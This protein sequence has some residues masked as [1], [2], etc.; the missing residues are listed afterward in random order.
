MLLPPGSEGH[1]LGTD[2]F[3]RDLL[4]RVVAA[5]GLSMLMAVGITAFVIVL[6]LVLGS[7]AGF[8]GGKTETG[9]IGLIDLT[10]GFPLLLV[11]VIFAGMVGKGLYALA[12]AAAVVLWAGFARIIRAQVKDPA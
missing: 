2:N 8:L 5:I 7:I 3:G 12:G 11:A 9:I 6:G 4:W 1:L 10:W